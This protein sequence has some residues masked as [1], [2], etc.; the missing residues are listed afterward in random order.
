[1]KICDAGDTFSRE[2]LR[3]L[4]YEQEQAE[5]STKQHE[6]EAV[7][8]DKYILSFTRKRKTK[9]IHLVQGC[10]RR[11]G[12]EIK[13]FQYF[14]NLADVPDATFCLDCCPLK[15]GAAAVATEVLDDTAGSTS[16]SS[17]VVSSDAEKEAEPGPAPGKRPRSSAKDG[18]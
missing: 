12:F 7:Q 6:E 18:T 10:W 16:S 5:E 11:I 9:K 13:D 2:E 1:M 3:A 8:E 15:K 17:T 4:H 14:S